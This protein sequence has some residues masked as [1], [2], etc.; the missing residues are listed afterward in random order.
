MQL[1]KRLI[2]YMLLI[3]MS[4]CAAKYLI[5]VVEA[6]TAARALAAFAFVSGI[7]QSIT[8]AIISKL[9]NVSKLEG[10]VYWSKKR[11]VSNVLKRISQL[12]IRLVLGVLCALA[13][14]LLSAAAFT[15]GVVKTPVWLI[16][17]SLFF[18]L[19]SLLFA[20]SA[21]LEYVQ[22]H[23]LEVELNEKVERTK[24]KQEYLSKEENQNYMS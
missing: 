11:L 19:T 22:I 20:V 10:L 6:K 8:L 1:L 17:L 15:L 13:I 24:K 4:Y 14:G 23:K 9:V 16:S 7:V 21:V 18:S 3:L 12:K 5:P 2:F